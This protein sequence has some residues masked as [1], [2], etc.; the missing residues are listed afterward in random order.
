VRKW[1]NSA[2]GLRSARPCAM[3]VRHSVRPR[4]AAGR[5]SINM[6]H[7]SRIE[8]GK[9]PPTENLTAALDAAFPSGGLVRRVSRGTA[10]MVGGTAWVRLFHDLG[11][12]IAT[13]RP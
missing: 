9:R 13:E 8:N 2:A 12:T 7:L 6:G 10:R 11:G 3:L 5:S 1:F 4:I